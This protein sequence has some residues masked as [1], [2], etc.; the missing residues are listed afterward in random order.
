MQQSLQ[1]ISKNPKS[2]EPPLLNSKKK[3]TLI[4]THTRKKKNQKLK[5]KITEDVRKLRVP[6][7]SG[8]GEKLRAE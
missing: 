1:R 8:C 2:K 4:D 7:T 6:A 5:V 3:K